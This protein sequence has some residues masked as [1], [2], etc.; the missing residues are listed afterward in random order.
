MV[1]PTSASAGPLGRAIR[2]SAA[3]DPVLAS[4]YADRGWRPLWIDRTRVRGQASVLVRLLRQADRDGL[5]PQSYRPERLEELIREARR[6]DPASLARAEVG[7]S[8]AL[9][10]YGSDLR[11]PGA[12]ASLS[13]IDPALPRDDPG[14]VLRRFARSASIEAGLAEL[15]RMNPIYQRLREALAK[16][17]PSQRPLILANLDRARA[18]PADPGPRFI[19]VDV[20]DGRLWMFENGAVTDSM[21]VVVGRTGE[22]T[23]AMA[24]LIR[25]LV[26]RPYWNMPPDLARK[27]LAPA[28]LR[29]GS[30]YLDAHRLEVLSDW[31]DQAQPLDAS[32]IDW[33]AAAAGEITLRVRQRPGPDNM[34]GQVKFML[35]NPLGIYLHDT[36]DKSL[37]KGPPR[38]ASAGCIRLQDAPRLMRWLTGRQM[39]IEPAGPWEETHGLEAP[40]PVYLLYLTLAPRADGRLQQRPD[41]YRRDPPLLARFT[42]GRTAGNP[43]G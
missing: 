16:A 2:V 19:L 39:T 30:G 1:L 15:T 9:A 10:A 32:T 11:T 13:F 26:L 33:A 17:A 5:D 7:L 27:A 8:R 42:S 12:G 6:S 40:V 21:R 18:L 25:R 3:P 29:Q 28:V 22:P 23:P 4:F 43:S 20:T 34:M 24:G 31:S 35:P 36:P 37:F 38:A 14:S 41:I